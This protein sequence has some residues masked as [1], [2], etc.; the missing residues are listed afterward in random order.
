MKYN[1]RYDIESFTKD[2]GFSTEEMADLFAEFIEVLALD[3][4]KMKEAFVKKN[5]N[6]IRSIIHDIKGV[7]GNY[8][9]IDVYSEASKI[10]YALK[11]ENYENLNEII[12]NF[13]VVLEKAF[14]EIRRFFY[15]KGIKI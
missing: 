12:F 11:N 15:E 1:C 6:G 14:E 7:S 13:Y 3:I 9:I 8:R 5:W 2:L 10:S 4:E